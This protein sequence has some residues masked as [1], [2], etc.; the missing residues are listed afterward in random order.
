M[1][2]RGKNGRPISKNE[3]RQ[4]WEKLMIDSG[5]YFLLDIEGI[6]KDITRQDM[7][8]MSPEKSVWL[9]TEP[10]REIYEM[11]AE[12]G[13]SIIEMV[14]KLTKEVESANKSRS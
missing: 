8:K 3:W 13:L 10:A 11:A 2:Y 1:R 7:L 6:R 14:N 5:Y 9:H 12:K 4:Q